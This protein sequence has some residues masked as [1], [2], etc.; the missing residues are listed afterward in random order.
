M[1]ITR[2]HIVL[3]SHDTLGLG[4]LRRNLAISR[5]LGQDHPQFSQLLLTGSPHVHRYPLPEQLDYIK[6][7]AVEK[8]RT[9]EYLA[10]TLDIDS[11]QI[12]RW[13]ARTALEA[14]RE[15]EPDILLVDK[16]PAGLK[17]EL[18]PAL[19]YLKRHHPTTLIVLGLRDIVDAPSATRAEWGAD[20]IYPLLER[21]YD[22]ILL[23][24]SRQFFDPVREY[25]L[26]RRIADKMIECGYIRKSDPL[27]PRWEVFDEIKPRA[28]FH[29]LIVTGPLVSREDYAR[30]KALA[31][32]NLPVTLME[33]TPDLMSY[34]QAADVV[35]SMGGYNTV[36]ELLALRQ[37]ALI[38]P[39]VNLR[40]E[41]LI[42]AERLAL[43]GL[44]RML[45]P[46]QLTPGRLLT[47]IRI[48]S[49]APRPDPEGAG[50]NMSGLDK[51]STVL[52]ELVGLILPTGTPRMTNLA[53]RWGS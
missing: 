43:R 20:D 1:I 21:M 8:Q 33:F 29:I 25:G 36:S 38:V 51:I 9:G 3:Y 34:L 13:R 4:H 27:R 7:P 6:F 31:E 53:A 16:A 23:Y 49:R 47:E 19:E 28:E 26:S 18:L 24:G 50:I 35:V 12:I 11:E 48:A 22:A 37:R 41:Q 46:D 10:R 42:R 15:F 30:L 39:R 2:P 52:G 40:A 44:V 5:R 17:G 45:H 32:P 14:V